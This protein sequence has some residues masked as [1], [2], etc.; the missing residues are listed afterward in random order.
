MQRIIR[1]MPSRQGQTVAASFMNALLNQSSS[2]APK[3]GPFYPSHQANIAESHLTG[4]QPPI[5]PMIPSKQKGAV[6]YSV[7]LSNLLD[8]PSA[9]T[10]KPKKKSFSIFSYMG[11]FSLSYHSNMAHAFVR[12]LLRSNSFERY[13]LEIAKMSANA[14]MNTRTYRPLNLI[15]FVTDTP[16]PHAISLKEGNVSMPAKHNDFPAN[17][18]KNASSSSPLTI[19]N[20]YIRLRNI[21]RELLLE[22]SDLDYLSAMLDTNQIHTKTIIN[23]DKIKLFLQYFDSYVDSTPITSSES[24]AGKKERI[25][26]GEA[27][28]YHTSK[29]NFKRKRLNIA[30]LSSIEELNE[31]QLE[32]NNNNELNDLLLQKKI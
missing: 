20:F 1:A 3:Y 21:N 4:Q 15:E 26:I 12:P 19:R 2:G 8:I 10:T 9:A 32:D 7:G 25:E 16:K 27:K 22:E 18:A 30:L 23:K 17:E 5:T 6:V 28:I 13:M 31:I 29:A 14:L 24:V 11:D